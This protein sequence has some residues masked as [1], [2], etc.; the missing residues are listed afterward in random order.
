[1]MKLPL[2]LFDLIAFAALQC[3]RGN[4]IFVDTDNC[5]SLISTEMSQT[6]W[7]LGETNP[8]GLCNQLF[9]IFSYIP[10]ARL[11]KT[12]LIIGPVYSRR[13]FTTTFN[14]FIISKIELQFSYLFD[15]NHYQRYWKEKGIQIVESHTIDKCLN[16]SAILIAQRPR[17]FS[18]SDS[19]LMDMMK[20]SN[21]A[22]PLVGK[23]TGIRVEENCRFTALYNHLQAGHSRQ[24]I[25]GSPNIHLQQVI[26]LKLCCLN[27][28]LISI[29]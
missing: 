5:R 18:L 4:P 7:L 6:Q 19:E 9:G 20:K 27:L 13:S 29:L 2:L 11:M 14:E 12:N 23:G 25:S 28:C 8:G 10:F 21:I 16:R 3:L 15:L 26:Y 24:T 1:M 22:L 17:F